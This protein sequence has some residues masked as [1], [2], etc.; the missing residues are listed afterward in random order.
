MKLEMTAQVRMNG[1]KGPARQ[2]R[3]QGKIP[4]ILYGQG[5]SLLLSMDPAEIRKILLTQAGST[6]LVTTR[7]QDHDGK[8]EERIAVIQDYQVD[9]ITGHLLHADLFEVSMDKT[10]R[11][12]VHVNVV[13]ETPIGV[14]RDKGVLHHV[15][16]ELHIE[17]LPAMIPD[18]INVDASALEI[19][20]GVHVRDV[21]PGEGIKLVDD[22]DQMV[23]NV[24]AP[25]SEAKLAAM[26]TSVAAEPGA[27]AASAVA[28]AEPAKAEGTPSGGGK[29]PEG[30]K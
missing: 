8:S 21:R 11:V 23:V 24:T 30:K 29:P 1:G 17:C 25:I 28:S 3:R 2:I 4:G 6:A 5:K 20:Q 9:P 15:L 19:G 16:R 18:Q 14:K 7:I 12:K 27:A 10:V 22:P 26:L 13:G